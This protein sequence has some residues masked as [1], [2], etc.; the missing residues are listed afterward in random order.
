MKVTPTAIPDLLVLEPRVH[1]DARGFFLESFNRRAFREATGIDA[2]FVQDNH[3][4]SAQGVLRGLHYQLRQAQGKL[5]RVVRG[6][7]YD[8]AV[9]IRKSSPTCG[10]WVGLE[11]SEENQR[12]LWIPPGFAHGFLVLSASA[13]FLY[14]TTDYYAPEHE[15][16]IAWNDPALGVEWPQVPGG[17]RLSAKDQVGTPFA[18][19]ELS[20]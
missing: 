15:R 1:G 4:R 12:Q 3:S 10:Q 5:V 7:V 16:C 18:Q 14:K 17:P 11:L 2:D 9:D 8:V 6:S 20:A 13:D 19:A